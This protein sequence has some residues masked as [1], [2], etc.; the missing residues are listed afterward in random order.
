MIPIF[1]KGDRGSPANYRPVSLTS[2]C[3][4]VME[5]ILHSQVMQHLEIHGI[6]S[7]QQDGFQE[8]RS[9]ENQLIL[10]LQDLAAGL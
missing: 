4:K 5:D 8:R 6:L 10:T 9:C 7:D 1:K 2:V 3:I